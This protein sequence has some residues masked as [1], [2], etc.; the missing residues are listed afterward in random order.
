MFAAL[1]IVVTVAIAAQRRRAEFSGGTRGLIG[2]IG[3]MQKYR[4]SATLGF[5]I[6]EHTFYVARDFHAK[7]SSVT[8]VDNI[9]AR[10]AT[11]CFATNSDYRAR[12]LILA[13]GNNI[14]ER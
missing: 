5:N 12:V 3:V 14:L 13:T 2:G 9:C 1:K 10:D 6:S 11:S 4:R 8:R 7:I